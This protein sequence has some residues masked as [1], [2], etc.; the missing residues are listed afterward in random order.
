MQKAFGIEARQPS[1]KEL[2]FSEN[3]VLKWGFKSEMLRYAYDICVDSKGKISMSYI[4]K[5]LESWSQKGFITVAD[6]EKSKK[7]TSNKSNSFS[8]YDKS[9]VEKLLNSDN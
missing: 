5:I 9:L 2:E 6:V 1:K 4:N 8:A 3:W 7:N